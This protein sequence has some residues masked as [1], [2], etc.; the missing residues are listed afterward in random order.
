VPHGIQ[1]FGQMPFQRQAMVCA[2][3]RPPL[4]LEGALHAFGGRP[5]LEELA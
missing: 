4:C 2:P 5:E 3:E 1:P